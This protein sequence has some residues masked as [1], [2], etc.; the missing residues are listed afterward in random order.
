[1]VAEEREYQSK[2]GHTDSLVHKSKSSLY[3]VDVSLGSNDHIASLDVGPGWR[4]RQYRSC[5][6]ADYRENT[7]ECTDDND[8]R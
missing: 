4:S 6:H 8:N 1:M 3:T 5:G 7:G 2:F